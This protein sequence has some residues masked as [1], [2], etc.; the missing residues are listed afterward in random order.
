[1]DENSFI[2]ELLLANRLV[3][4]QRQNEVGGSGGVM[5]SAEDFVL[6]ALERSNPAKRELTLMF[7]VLC[8]LCHLLLRT[9]VASGASGCALPLSLTKLG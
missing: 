3:A 2:H 9:G 8:L 5:S 7:G 6:I 4:F 1:V